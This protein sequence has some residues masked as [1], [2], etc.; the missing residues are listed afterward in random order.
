MFGGA[1]HHVL[2]HENRE[3]AKRNLRAGT[4]G[5]RAKCPEDYYEIDFR[6]LAIF[7]KHPRRLM[8]IQHLLETKERGRRIK[9]RRVMCCANFDTRRSKVSRRQRS[10]KTKD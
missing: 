6:F 4:L 5:P 10:R 7:K 2:N 1:E 3:E 9:E 8:H